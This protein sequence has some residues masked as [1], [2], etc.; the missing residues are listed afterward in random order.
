MGAVTA[1]EK[2]GWKEIRESSKKSDS[3]VLSADRNVAGLVHLQIS[4]K[5]LMDLQ[6][7]IRR[8][9]GIQLGIVITA[10][11]FLPGVS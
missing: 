5:Y 8:I 3:D 7:A 11:L 4:C 1:V 9:L 10:Y 2:C 6:Q